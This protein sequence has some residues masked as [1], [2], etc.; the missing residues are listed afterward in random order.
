MSLN[1]E[2]EPNDLLLI[3]LLGIKH[4]SVYFNDLDF[5][6]ETHDYATRWTI[7][8]SAVDVDTDTDRDPTPEGDE[9]IVEWVARK[10][11]VAPENVSLQQ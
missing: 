8:P 10:F 3:K 7:R 6:P 1:I 2:R 9:A 5:R 11:G 4:V